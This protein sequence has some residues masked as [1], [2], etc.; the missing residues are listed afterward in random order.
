M[1]AFDRSFQVVSSFGI[2]VGTVEAAEALYPDE[3]PVEGVVVTGLVEQEG[4]E[5]LGSQWVPV[6]KG[7][8]RVE[9]LGVPVVTLFGQA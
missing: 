2:L 1:E 6:P 8:A 5:L 9:S 7:A 4:Q 3:A